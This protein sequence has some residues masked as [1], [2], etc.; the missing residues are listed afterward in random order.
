[1]LQVLD[2]ARRAA[3]ELRQRHALVLPHERLV[4]TLDELGAFLDDGEVSR[5]VGV[6]HVVEADAPQRG[7]HLEGDRRAGLQAEQLAHGRAGRGRRLDDDVLGGVVQS[8]PDVVGLVLGVQGA[9][10]AAVHALAAVDADDGTERHVLEGLDGDLVAAADGLEHPDFLDVDAGA[11]APAAAD[12]LVHVA[13]HGVARVVRL[14]QRLLRVTEGE[15]GDAVLLG[16]RLQLAV[17]V[18]HAAGAL[19]VVLA[20][21]KLQ[22]VPARLA[23]LAVMRVDLHLIDDREGAGRLQRALTLHLHDAD[24]AHAGHVQVRVVAQRGDV[25]AH[26]AGCLEDGGPERD[27]GLDA[28][29]GDAH[30]GADGVRACR[31]DHAPVLLRQRRAMDRGRGMSHLHSL[32]LVTRSGRG[33]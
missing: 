19:A 9:D 30:L 23:D 10:R 16:E 26:A 29:D 15:L 25:D 2:P 20:Q 1:M 8:L 17:A 32:A 3:R 7:V 27:L 28:V 4:E 18:A 11:H 33:R 13:H 31:G 24:A 6:E 14:G 22:H 21:Q 12:A 5:E